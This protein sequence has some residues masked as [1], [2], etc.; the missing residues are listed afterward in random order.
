[1]AAIT[2]FPLT[3]ASCTMLANATICALYNLEGIESLKAIAVF[4]L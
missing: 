3:P 2:S 4:V 1:M